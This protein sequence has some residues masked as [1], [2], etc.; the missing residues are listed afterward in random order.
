MPAA[1]VPTSSLPMLALLG[2]AVGFVAGAFGVGG[3]FL[4]TPLMVALFRVPLPIAVGTSL[5]QIIGTA[6]ASLLR[7]QALRQGELRF[8]LLMLP[9]GVLGVEAGARTLAWLER[10][11]AV[12]IA[13]RP[14]PL[15]NLVI[16]ALYA[17]A[18]LAVAAVYWAHARS[19]RDA[20]A[21]VRDGPL[22]RL[23]LPPLVDLPAI[24]LRRVSA[25]LIAY[26]GLGM[27]F[28]S[29]LIGIG[30]GVA[31]MPV[32]LYGF[33][34]PFRHAA[35]TGV[36]VLLATSMTGT[37][38]HGLR[39]HVDLRLAIVLLVGSTVT[40][41][42]GA[43]AVKRWSARSLTRLHALVVMAAVAAVA[44]DLARRITSGP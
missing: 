23:R 33:G 10:A 26:L 11:G 31:L 22:A 28:L 2:I 14:V 7:H 20:L 4:M 1:G 24:P 13:G 25:P 32:M 37:V 27:G 19:S 18:L 12:A 3:G 34:F 8:D 17:V 29:G 38:A 21:E 39:G 9:G 43:L 35:G 41:Q 30:G 44:W 40:A 5:C 36:L 42:L 6:T 16:E 15:A